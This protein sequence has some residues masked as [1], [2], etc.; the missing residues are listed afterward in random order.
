M[1]FQEFKTA[2]RSFEESDKCQNVKVKSE[3]SVIYFKPGEKPYSPRCYKCNQLGH[4]AN[5]CSNK[6]RVRK[7]K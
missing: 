6:I 5:Q 1:D 3:D 2:L 4:K 7:C